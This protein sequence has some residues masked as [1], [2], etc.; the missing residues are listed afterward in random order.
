M[1]RR[2]VA[3]TN[4]VD[5]LRMTRDSK[6]TLSGLNIVDI[7]RMVGGSGNDFSAITRKPN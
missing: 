3:E 1:R 5:I 4:R 6:D 2:G 7:N